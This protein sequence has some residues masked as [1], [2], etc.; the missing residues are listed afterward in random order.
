MET[1]DISDAFKQTQTKIIKAAKVSGR[2]AKQVTLIA[3]S[4]QQ[5]EYRIEASLAAG[6]R[7]FGEN[8]VR[9]NKNAGLI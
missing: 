9:S 8:R 4:K 1:S 5:H 7:V 6:Q 2:S 3:V